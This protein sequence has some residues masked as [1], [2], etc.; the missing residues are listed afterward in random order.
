MRATAGAVE[1]RGFRA[2]RRVAETV[3]EQSP[4]LNGAEIRGAAAFA[5]VLQ[6]LA[7]RVIPKRQSPCESGSL[8]KIS[9]AYTIAI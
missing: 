9:V 4:S 3:F 2:S 5:S 8:V 6:P 7:T 1:R